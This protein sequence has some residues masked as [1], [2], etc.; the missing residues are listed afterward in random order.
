MFTKL[1]IFGREMTLSYKG[2]FKN[3]T[4]VGAFFTFLIFLYV[5]F[6]MTTGLL[7]VIINKTDSIFKEEIYAG[8]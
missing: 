4:K 3:K 2:N 6:H 1:D 5:V 7:Q 8:S